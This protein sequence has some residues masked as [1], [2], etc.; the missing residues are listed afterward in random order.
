MIEGSCSSW[1]LLPFTIVQSIII[2]IT[3]NIGMVATMFGMQKI[4]IAWRQH[5]AQKDSQIKKV[6]PVINNK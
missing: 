3:L 6:D 5:K 1:S 4:I 2:G